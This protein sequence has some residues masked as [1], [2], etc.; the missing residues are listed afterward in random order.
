MVEVDQV[1]RLA[2]GGC[3]QGL[4]LDLAR[5]REDADPARLVA[6][7]PQP[8]AAEDVHHR[9]VGG[10]AVE[11]G[12][13]LAQPTSQGFARVQHLH[14]SRPGAIVRGTAVP[15][16]A[17]Q[18]RLLGKLGP[19]F[20]PVGQGGALGEGVEGR[21]QAPRDPQHARVD[22]VAR[23][24]HC[25]LFEPARAALRNLQRAQGALD[26]GGRRRAPLGPVRLEIVAPQHRQQFVER[27]IFEI[28]FQQFR[29]R[30]ERRRARKQRPLLD[31]EGDSQAREH[32][33]DPVG[34]VAQR[35]EDDSH[36]AGP[37]ALFGEEPLDARADKLDLAEWPRGRENFQARD[38]WRRDF[39]ISGFRVLG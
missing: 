3:R 10:A 29:H 35:P 5:G 7:V 27:P 9:I 23:L 1:G 26:H 22:A 16:R 37:N 36:V 31:H 15:H 30:P 19:C 8:F 38:G 17:E 6:R 14:P 13:I 11:F 18:A 12:Q 21:R 33:V 28:E 4:V 2:A 39:A 25:Q 20:G 32:F 34:R 24:Q